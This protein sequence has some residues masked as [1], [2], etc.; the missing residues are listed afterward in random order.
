MNHEKGETAMQAAPHSNRRPAASEV[1]GRI[2][3]YVFLC[4][5]LLF[6]A[7]P[8]LWA[9]TSSLRDNA[10]IMKYI[11]PFSV[12][13]VIPEALTLE[14]YQNIFTI[15][16]FGRAVLNTIM[17]CT[18]TIGVGLLINSLAGYSLSKF[19]YR[20]RNALFMLVVFTIMI[21]G[22]GITIPLYSIVHSMGLT[23]TYWAL[24]LPMFANG[25]VI[26]LFKQFFEELPDSLLESAALDGC[27]PT[28]T[29]FRIVVPLSKPAM[30]SAGLTLFISQWDA[31]LWPLL[32]GRE[33]RFN[34]VQVALTE[35]KT[36]YYTIW[37]ELY[38]AS[39]LS[40]LI[41][42]LLLV[43]FQKYFIQGIAHTGIK[44]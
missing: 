30:I 1:I 32:V 44:D 28:A 20:F 11:L 22:E 43:P 2:A 42:L 5:V 37:N 26:F 9:L 27:G 41:P 15:R 36:Q 6:S 7:L 29:F 23:N 4:A 17:I 18:I 38:A 16:T 10:E 40:A 21:P 25:I 8:T 33:D 34:M 39:V 13:T 12:R 31:F 3:L 19:N 14:A 35:F 24:L